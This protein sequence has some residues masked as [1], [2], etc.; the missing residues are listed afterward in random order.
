M[1]GL[2]AQIDSPTVAEGPPSL[3]DEMSAHSTVVKALMDVLYRSELPDLRFPNLIRHLIV[4]ADKWGIEKVPQMIKNALSAPASYDRD[5]DRF[6]L[7]IGLEDYAL[8]AK[9]RGPMGTVRQCYQKLLDEFPPVELND[10]TVLDSALKYRNNGHMHSHRMYGLNSCQYLDFI[11][12]PPRVAWALQRAAVM[13]EHE[14][15]DGHVCSNQRLCWNQREATA[16]GFIRIMMP[17]CTC[18]QRKWANHR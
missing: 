14:V 17:D 9:V 18:V 13:W 3:G 8:A 10:R 15:D 16:E 11:R 5:F 1:V 4:L 7:A 12:L 2:H 6:L